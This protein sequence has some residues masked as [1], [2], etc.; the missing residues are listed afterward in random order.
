MIIKITVL[1]YSLNFAFLLQTFKNLCLLV[2]KDSIKKESISDK[3]V[4]NMKIN[5]SLKLFSVNIKG[6]FVNPPSFLKG[7]LY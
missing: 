4:V 5:K 7:T 6:L 3:V 1:I 2:L